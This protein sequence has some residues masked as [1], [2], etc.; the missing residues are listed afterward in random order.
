VPVHDCVRRRGT[1]AWTQWQREIGKVLPPGQY[2]IEDIPLDDPI[3]RSQF[4]ITKVPQI[5]N[6]GFWRRSG[7]GQSTSERGYDSDVV[8]FRGI[9]DQAGRLMVVMTHNTDVADSWE[10]E[11]EDPGFF[12][13]FS[14][15]GYALG[16]NVLLH[17]LTH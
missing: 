4:I 13:Q 10:R 7:G 9:R 15:D 17:A 12:Y 1:P 3:L 16:V 5:T 6:I 8:N 11:G 2:P 14:P